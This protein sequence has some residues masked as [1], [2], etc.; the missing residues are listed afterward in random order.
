MSCMHATRH[1]LTV[2]EEKQAVVSEEAEKLLLEGGRATQI[3]D[4]TTA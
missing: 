4:S 3:T 1:S 2:L